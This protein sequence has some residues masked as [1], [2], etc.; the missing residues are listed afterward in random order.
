MR[1]IAVINADW[2]LAHS[3]TVVYVLVKR[4]LG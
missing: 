3:H 1:S 2:S 4:R